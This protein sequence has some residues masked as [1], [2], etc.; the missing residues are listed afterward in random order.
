MGGHVANREGRHLAASSLPFPVSII[1]FAF[2]KALRTWPDG[3]RLANL[4]AFY[5]SLDDYLL[6]DEEAALLNR[7]DAALA[8]ARPDEPAMG[9]AQRLKAANYGEAVALRKALT[10]KMQE[11]LKLTEAWRKIHATTDDGSIQSLEFTGSA[12]RH[13]W[14]SAAKVAGV[15][16]FFFVGIVMERDVLEGAEGVWTKAFLVF[17]GLFLIGFFSAALAVQGV[18]RDARP[19]LVEKERLTNHSLGPHTPPAP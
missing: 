19:D 6:T 10:E 3:D 12:A 16:T 18:L 4:K 7:A 5:V 13:S 17:L 9:I 14:Q 1:E 15:V 11:R 2:A 8:S